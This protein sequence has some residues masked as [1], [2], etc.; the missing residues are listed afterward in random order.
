ME[1]AGCFERRPVETV[2]RLIRRRAQ[3]VDELIQL[4]AARRSQVQPSS[5]ELD[6][7]IEELV[8]EVDRSQSRCVDRITALTG[9]FGRQ[10]SGGIAT[11]LRDGADGRLLGR[12]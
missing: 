12:G 11:G 3:V 10:Q 9:E 6:V 2:W 4:D 1:R 8:R 5:A 7:A